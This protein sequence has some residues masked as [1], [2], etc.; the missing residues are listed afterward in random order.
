MASNALAKPEMSYVYAG[1][2]AV[3]LMLAWSPWMLPA[4]RLFIKRSTSRPSGN[5]H[6]ESSANVGSATIQEQLG[7][8]NSEALELQKKAVEQRVASLQNIARKQSTG[9]LP[10]KMRYFDRPSA[11]QWRMKR[12]TRAK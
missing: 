10:T 2:T 6:H 11:A 4:F 3:L 1:V 12:Y 9:P 8:K 5:K 7:F